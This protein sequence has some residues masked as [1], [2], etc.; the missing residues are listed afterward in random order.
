MVTSGVSGGVLLSFLCLLDPGDEIL[1]PD[2]HFMMYR[3]LAVLCGAVPRYYSLYPD[4]KLPLEE[5]A[6]LVTKKT[7]VVLV[8]LVLKLN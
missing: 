8:N 7:K 6:S 2:P 1:L 5:M 3:H 4:F